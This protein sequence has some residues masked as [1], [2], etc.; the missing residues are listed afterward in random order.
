M[1]NLRATQWL[2][3]FTLIPGTRL[4]SAEIRIDD[5]SLLGLDNVRVETTTYHGKVGLKMKEKESG[6]GGLALL[7]GLEF[8]DGEIDLE[9]SGAPSKTADPTA[10]GF[11]GVIFRIQADGSHAES[12]YL[13][14]SNGRAD[15][16]LNRNHSVQYV[17]SPEWTWQRLRTETPG[18]YESYADMQDGEWTQMRVVVH[19]K[20]AE[21]Y[22][23][24]AAQPCLIVKDLKLGESQGGVALWIGPGTEGY[25]RNVRI[26]RSG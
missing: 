21:L 12:I 25:F 16:Q 7:K 20:E 26:T 11:I 22:V 24:G 9:V 15:N 6:P 19:G 17:S 4:H 3:A 13:R 1:K 8:R 14:P 5:T 2:L 18:Q 23:G 10:R